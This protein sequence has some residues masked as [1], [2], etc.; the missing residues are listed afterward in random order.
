M[1]IWAFHNAPKEL[2]DLSRHGGDEDYIAVRRK[3]EWENHY[4][5]FFDD[6]SFHW[7]GCSSISRHDKDEFEIRIG[8]HS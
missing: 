2:Q 3:S 5:P 1:C 8:A 6:E 4:I 7:F